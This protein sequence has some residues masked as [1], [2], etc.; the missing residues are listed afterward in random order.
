ML[1]L[2]NMGIRNLVDAREQG[3]TFLLKAI[4]SSNSKC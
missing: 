1:I 2:L 3:L 4:I